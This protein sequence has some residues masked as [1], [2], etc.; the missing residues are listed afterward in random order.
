ML[1]IKS[2][3]SRLRREKVIYKNPIFIYNI[4]MMYIK[5]EKPQMLYIKMRNVI[6]K[7]YKNM[8]ITMFYIKM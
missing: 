1:Y 8:K 6:Y 5:I 7:I 4:F 3:F 2:G